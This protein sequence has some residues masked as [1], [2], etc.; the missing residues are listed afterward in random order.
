MYLHAQQSACIWSSE[1]TRRPK[2]VLKELPVIGGRFQN[3]NQTQ[4]SVGARG[5]REGFLEEALPMLN[6]NTEARVTQV[7]KEG[8]RCYRQKEKHGH[9][10]KNKNWKLVL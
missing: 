2:S 5:S 3:S 6:H 7:K 8:K 9:K 1:M 4:G 10:G